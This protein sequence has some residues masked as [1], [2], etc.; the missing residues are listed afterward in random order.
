MP[1]VPCPGGHSY[2]NDRLKT[3]LKTSSENAK[4]WDKE[5][6]TLR[7]NNARLKTA[8]E[9]SH[10]NVEEWKVQLNTWQ[11]ESTTLRG[12]VRQLEQAQAEAATVRM[13]SR[14]GAG[15]ANLA[16]RGGAHTAW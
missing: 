4:Q 11:E 10:A 16:L 12:Q 1:P 5:L 2:E 9:E 15:D 7:N 3:A 6:Q 14:A 13:P 8:L